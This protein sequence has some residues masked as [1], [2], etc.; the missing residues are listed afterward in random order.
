MNCMAD[1]AQAK[2]YA[3]RSTNKALYDAA[4]YYMAAAAEIAFKK[5]HCGPERA[6]LIVKKVYVCLNSACSGHLK[7]CHVTEALGWH[8]YTVHLPALE[9][10]PESTPCHKPE[11]DCQRFCSQQVADLI[12]FTLLDD[13]GWK[14]FAVDAFMRFFND[15]VPGYIAGAQNY[16]FILE[17]LKEY[18][19]DLRLHVR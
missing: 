18:D 5:Y 2:R 10:I 16:P 3:V 1:P 17:N 19:L 12:A 8:N 6:V 11:R 13:L 7:L 9:K 15:Y 4:T 14:P